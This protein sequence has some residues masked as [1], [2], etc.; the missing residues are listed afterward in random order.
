MLIQEGL[1]KVSER[2]CRRERTQSRFLRE[3]SEILPGVLRM[4]G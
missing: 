4:S 2:T 3:A 1:A